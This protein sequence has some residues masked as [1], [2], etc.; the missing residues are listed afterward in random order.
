MNELHLVSLESSDVATWDFPM[1]KAELQRRLDAYAG[2]VY[3][4]ETIKEAKSD[5]ATLNKVKKAITDAEK[6]YKAKCLEPYEAIRPQINELVDLVEEQRLLIDST[7]KDF[8]TRQKEEKE[9][10]VRKYYDRKA[11]VLGTYADSLYVKLFDKKWTNATTGKA[12]YEEAIQ[13]AINQAVMDL[14]TIKS[15]VSPFAETLIETYVMTLSVDKAKEKDLQLTEAAK[16]AGLTNQTGEANGNTTPTTSAITDAEQG[17]TMRIFA[18]Q[19]QMNQL[20][21]FMKAIGVGYEL[22]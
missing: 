18:S 19:N 21:D 17:M 20:I 10:Q 22:L 3:T 1:M 4:D 2:L 16:K 15:W 7:V 13:I 11:V 9:K 12:K 6:A 14:E 8:E 5:R